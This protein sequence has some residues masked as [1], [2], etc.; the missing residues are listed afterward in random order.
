LQIFAEELKL[1]SSSLHKCLQP[2][3]ASLLGANILY[4]L[5]PLKKSI[6]IWEVPYFSLHVLRGRDTKDFVQVNSK[7]SIFS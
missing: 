4:V 2:L 3:L 5:H 1:L 6:K 7:H